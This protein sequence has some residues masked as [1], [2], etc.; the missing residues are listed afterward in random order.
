[1]KKYILSIEQVRK[2]VS[3]NH[4][5]V[6]AKMRLASRC[7]D[8]RYQVQGQLAPI[9]VPGAD[10][11][12]LALILA[13]GNSYGFEV[14]L[15]KAY[16]VLVEMVGGEKNLQFHTDS[17]AEK[18]LTLGGCGHFKQ[19]TLDS[20]AYNLDKKQVEKIRAKFTSA[21]KKGAKEIILH[22]EHLEGA[23]L[24]VSGPYSLYPRYNLDS[25]EGKIEVQVFVYHQ[26]L[27]QERYKKLAEELVKQ[28][29]VKLYKSLNGEYLYQVLSEM[30]ENHLMETSRRLAKGLPIYQVNFEADGGFEIKEIGIV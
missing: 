22:G 27:A 5:K 16:Q 4:Y 14:D 13:T 2:I 23:V 17:H 9:G 29:A 1:M 15:D 7:I 10:A 26:S 12:D 11:G 24:I 25:Q 30:A 20:Q 28:K 8:G 18:N 21:K 3:D 19:M 6:E